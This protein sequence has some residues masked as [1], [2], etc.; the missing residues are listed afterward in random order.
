MENKTMLTIAE[1]EAVV[2]QMIG[3]KKTTF[4][5]ASELQRA[6][7][8]MGLK[9][10]PL[11]EGSLWMLAKQTYRMENNPKKL[12]KPKLEKPTA[13]LTVAEAFNEGQRLLS[14]GHRLNT[15]AREL[16]RRGVWSEKN[17]GF[18]AVN[19]IEHI[20]S[21]GENYAEKLRMGEA[22]QPALPPSPPSHV[23]RAVP[24]DKYD[25]LRRNIAAVIRMD[26]TDSTKLKLIA[27]LV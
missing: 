10:S 15:A 4:E 9:G 20:I 14:L 16:H 21:Y 27:E 6:G 12:N 26:T 8:V 25:R 2:A 18:Y 11:K 3:E 17:N 19:T 7:G 22:R 23:A 24:N 5:I 13:A 1:A